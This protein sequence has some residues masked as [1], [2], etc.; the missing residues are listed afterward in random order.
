MSRRVGNPP[1][2]RPT[3]V[4]RLTEN[5]TLR[6]RPREDSRRVL[7][8]LYSR[9]RYWRSPSLV[10]FVWV[11][12]NNTGLR[13]L[14]AGVCFPVSVTTFVSSSWY[15]SLLVWMSVYPFFLLRGTHVK[16]RQSIIIFRRVLGL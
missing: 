2:L 16:V 1:I 6:S 9:K 3:S 8:A 14:L 11:V 15:V 10:V 4:S 12:S 5:G 7:L 13:G